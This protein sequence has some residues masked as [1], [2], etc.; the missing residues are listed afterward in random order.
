MY[1]ACGAVA[2][3][4]ACD[5]AAKRA[6]MKVS[7]DYIHEMNF[8]DETKAVIDA[9]ADIETICKGSPIHG[10]DKSLLV[11][12]VAFNVQA[13]PPMSF[14]VS[15]E[16][17]HKELHLQKVKSEQQDME[18]M[19]PLRFKRAALAFASSVL[20]FACRICTGDSGSVMSLRS[21]ATL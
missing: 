21:A 13:T 17:C 12:G 19:N 7:C 5:T 9:G 3:G 2:Y 14:G 8:A 10:W 20:A 11:Q 4:D 16:M 6:D 1:A 18:P 15:S